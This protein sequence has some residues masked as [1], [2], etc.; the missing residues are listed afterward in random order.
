MAKIVTP[1]AG[2]RFEVELLGQSVMEFAFFA[3][4]E[5][6]K[7]KIWLH[8]GA[9][10]VKVKIPTG[11]PA[12]AVSAIEAHHVVI[13]I[14]NPDASEEAAFAGLWTGGHVEHEAAHFSEKF[15]AHVIELVVLFIEAIGVDENHLE[16]AVRK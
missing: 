2:L 6:G 7:P 16:E 9:P 8:V 1:Q 10:A 4:D 5:G 13:L 14:F 11:V 15:T 12:A 3:V